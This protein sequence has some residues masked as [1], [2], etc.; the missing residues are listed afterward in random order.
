MR[1]G[2]LGVVIVSDCGNYRNSWWQ[3]AGCIWWCWWTVSAMNDKCV[4][5]LDDL[6]IPFLLWCVFLWVCYDCV[7]YKCMVVL[8]VAWPRLTGGGHRKQCYQWRA[9]VTIC[10]LSEPQPPLQLAW[11]PLAMDKTVPLNTALPVF[12][13]HSCFHIYL[14]CGD[15]Y[16]YML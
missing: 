1:V 6:S 12:S 4:M 16:Y 13:T 3:H 7:W 11:A 2:W 14:W 5:M 10:P 8:S 15:K 9:A